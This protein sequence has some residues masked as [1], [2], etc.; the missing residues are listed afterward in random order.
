M[1]NNNLFLQEHF[2]KL[3]LLMDSF[4]DETKGFDF[5]LNWLFNVGNHEDLERKLQETKREKLRNLSKNAEIKK[6]AL[7][8]FKKYLPCCK[9]KVDFTSFWV[10]IHIL[11]TLNKSYS[12][13]NKYDEFF[14]AS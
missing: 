2:K 8:R 9:F 1:E 13:K 12:S 5:D 10:N 4:W 3:I 14:Q 7:D 6:L 11:H